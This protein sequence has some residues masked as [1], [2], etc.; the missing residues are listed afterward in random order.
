MN[1]DI[2]CVYKYVLIVA[3]EYKLEV[4]ATL[5]TKVITKVWMNRINIPLSTQTHRAVFVRMHIY[6]DTEKY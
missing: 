2:K 4:C 1:R 6:A 5:L 3:S